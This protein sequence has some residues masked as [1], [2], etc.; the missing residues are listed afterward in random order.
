MLQ[1]TL[2][3]SYIKSKEMQREDCEYGVP[4]IEIEIKWV[5]VPFAQGQLALPACWADFSSE[6][7]PAGSIGCTEPSRF[8]K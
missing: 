3:K 5:S 2:G 1:G 7:T 4:K 8:G 6:Q